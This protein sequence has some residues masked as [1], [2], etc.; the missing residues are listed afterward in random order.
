[1]IDLNKL[2]AESRVPQVSVQEE[3]EEED[4]LVASSSESATSV[5]AKDATAITKYPHYDWPITTSLFQTCFPF[6]VIFD[7]DLV[8]RFMGV[9]LTRIFPKAVSSG[10]KLTDYFDLCRPA[11]KLTY[12]NIRVSLHNIFIMATKIPVMSSHGS[13]QEALQFRGQ[14]IPTSSRAGADILFL[15]S[16]R[17]SN[18]EELEHQGLY[19]SDIPIHDVTRDLLLLNNHFRVEMSIATELEHT[20]KDLQIQKS[21]VE[22][23]KRRADELLHTMLP[24]TIASELKSGA[25]VTAIAWPSVTILFSDIKGFTTICNSCQPMQVVGM[26]NRLYTLFDSQSERHGVYK[27]RGGVL[28]THHLSVLVI[29]AGGNYRRCLHGGSRA[30]GH[31]H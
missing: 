18:I 26:L 12:N 29:L 2:L 7:K 31:P 30:P 24:P 3:E 16:P 21:R 4:A 17:I 23:E 5:I 19:L 1:M 8:V 9:S 15:G 13:D 11:V 27:V 10:T 25:E 22:Q 20:K 14:M 6:H 28:Y